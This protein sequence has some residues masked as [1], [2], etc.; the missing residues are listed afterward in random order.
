MIYRKQLPKPPEQPLQR[1]LAVSVHHILYLCML[2]VPIL[3]W[4]AL[5]AEVDEFS[6]FGVALPIYMGVISFDVGDVHELAGNAFVCLVGLHAVAGIAHH[7]ILKDDVLKRMLP[8][9]K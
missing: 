8:F 1:K 6:V 2:F 9:L 7:Y 4:L 5:S 3:G